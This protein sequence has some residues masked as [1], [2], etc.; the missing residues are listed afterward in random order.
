MGWAQGAGRRTRA[1]DRTRILVL[2]DL[3]QTPE[4]L[5]LRLMG[6]NNTLTRAS[7]D[8]AALPFE[9]PLRR[10]VGSDARPRA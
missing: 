2:A 8:L 5:L 3:P 1:V 9:H 10:Q 4:T 7:T 6:R